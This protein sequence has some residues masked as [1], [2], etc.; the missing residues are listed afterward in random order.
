[1]SKG[2]VEQRAAV[3]LIALVQRG[4]AGRLAAEKLGIDAEEAKAVLSAAGQRY[5]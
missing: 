3:R 4:M 1:M 2:N 5:R